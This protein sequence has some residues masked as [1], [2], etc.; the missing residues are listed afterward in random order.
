MNLVDRL[1]EIRN[2]LPSNVKI[3]AVSKTQPAASIEILYREIGQRIFGENRV[4]ELESKYKI[5]PTDIDWHFIGH[6]Q[7]NKVKNIVPF[8]KLVHSVDSLKLLIEINKEGIKINRCIPCLLQFHIAAEETKYG[9][10]NDEVFRMLDDNLFHELSN[11]SVKGVMGM[12]TYTEDQHQ[13]RTE[14]KTLFSIFNS[15]KSRYFARE[16]NFCEV[17][18]GMS[19]DYQLAVEEGSTIVRIGSGIFGND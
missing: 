4:L 17:S 19:N 14:F 15:I 11:I 6:L 1:N 9:F 18:M 10:S 8:V 12:A 13:I 3:V 16:P 2:T 7:T 5:L